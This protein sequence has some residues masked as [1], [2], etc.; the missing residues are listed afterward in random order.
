MAV[1]DLKNFHKINL[2]DN[3]KHYTMFSRATM[4]KVTEIT[5]QRGTKCHFNEIHEN[6][7]DYLDFMGN[8]EKDQLDLNVIDQSEVYFRYGVIQINEMVRDLQ[9]WETLLTSSMMQRPIKR[10]IDNDYQNL[11]IWEDI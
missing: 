6:F 10:I 8:E 7:N 3:P 11:K 1:D 2:K 4:G 5:Q 9:H